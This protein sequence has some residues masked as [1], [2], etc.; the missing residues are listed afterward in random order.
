MYRGW[1]VPSHA[2]ASTQ[3]TMRKILII[4]NLNPRKQTQIKNI[5]KY[6]III[7]A[8]AHTSKLWQI[9]NTNNLESMV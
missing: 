4:D 5:L 2:Y 1:G 6:S 8:H 7:I 9:F 3:K